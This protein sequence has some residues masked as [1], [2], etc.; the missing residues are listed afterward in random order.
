MLINLHNLL[1]LPVITESG[2]RL[3][4]V[5]DVNFDIENHCV[6]SYVVYAGLLSKHHLI[7]PSQIVAVTKEQITVDDAFLKEIEEESKK[8]IETKAKPVVG[9]AM[10]SK[11]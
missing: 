2:V 7:K 6:K 8:Q 5:H 3:G 9:L 1:H 10:S 11:K 4:K